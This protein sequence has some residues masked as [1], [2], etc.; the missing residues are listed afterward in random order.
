MSKNFIKP[1]QAT[2]QSIYQTEKYY[3]KYAVLFN[4]AFLII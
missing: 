3:I 2:Y 4:H 1:L